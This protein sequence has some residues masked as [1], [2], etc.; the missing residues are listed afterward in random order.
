MGGIKY[1]R[2]QFEDETFKIV[3]GKTM[4]EVVKK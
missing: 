4:L 2:L 3:K 1:F